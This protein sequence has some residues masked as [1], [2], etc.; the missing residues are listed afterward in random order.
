[1]NLSFSNIE[2]ILCIDLSLRISLFQTFS[3]KFKYE[4]NCCKAY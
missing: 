3:E 1:M 4:K 2:I